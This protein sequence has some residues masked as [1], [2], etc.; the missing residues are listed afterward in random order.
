MPC[1]NLSRLKTPLKVLIASCCL[2]SSCLTINSGVTAF[3]CCLR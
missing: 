2:S 3:C 1:I